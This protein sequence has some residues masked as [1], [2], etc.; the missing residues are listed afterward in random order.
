MALSRFFKAFFHST[1]EEFRHLSAPLFSAAGNPIALYRMLHQTGWDLDT[2]FGV[3]P[4]R[5]SEDF[6]LA[7]QT[8]E[9]ISLAITNEDDE[10][11]VQEAHTRFKAFIERIE[12]LYPTLMGLEDVADTLDSIVPEHAAEFG[13][14]LFNHL[15]LRYLHHR[16]PLAF[17]LGKLFGLIVIHPASAIYP[18]NNPSKAPVRYPIERPTINWQGLLNPQTNPFAALIYQINFS[19]VNSLKSFLNEVQKLFH[20]FRRELYQSIGNRGLDGMVVRLDATGLR[21]ERGNWLPFPEP[22]DPPMT[23]RLSEPGYPQ[24]VIDQEAW[25]LL[26][27]PEIKQ[28]DGSVVIFQQDWV[29]ITLLPSLDTTGGQ[30][31]PGLYLY[32]NDNQVLTFEIV[33]GVGLEFPLEMLSDESGNSIGA[34]AVGRLVVVEGED[35]KLSIDK[36]EITGNFR[37]G[38][39]E[40]LSIQE[41]QLTIQGIVL[42][43]TDPEAFPFSVD[44]S[45]KLMLP[46][47]SG[48]IS[49]M[50]R[51]D[52]DQVHLQTSAEI[53]L[54]NGV[55]LY[56]IEESRPVLEMKAA[57][58]GVFAFGVAA[59]F[60]IPRQNIGI[61]EIEI[62]GDLELGRNPDD[63]WDIK[64]FSAV[65]T[66]QNLSWELPGGIK[67]QKAGVNIFFENMEFSASLHGQL[68]LGN[69]QTVQMEA[70]LLFPDINDPENIQIDTLLEVGDL[71]FFNQLYLFKAQLSLKVSTRPLTGSIEIIDGSGGFMAV[72]DLDQHPGLSDFHLAVDL[73]HTVFEFNTN[74]FELQLKAGKFLLPK[75]FN[76]GG[77]ERASARIGSQPISLVHEND[78]LAFHASIVLEN[79]GVNLSENG[80]PGFAGLLETAFLSLNSSEPIPKIKG[81]K[82]QITIPLP[83]QAPL[84]IAFNEVDWDLSG[85]PTGSVYLA[86]DI[87]FSLGGGFALKLLGGIQNGIQTGLTIHRMT[88]SLPQFILN[89]AVDLIIPM[90]MLTS[91]NGD[92]IYIGSSGSISWNTGEFPVPTLDALRI[93]G[94]FRLGGTKGIRIQDGELTASGIAHMLHP[95]QAQPFQLLLSGKIYLGDN[96]PGAGIQD[97][98]FI[99]TGTDFPEFDFKGF[100][101]RPGEELLGAVDQLPLK[102][103]DLEV[104]FIEP[105]PMPQR[106]NP[107]NIRVTLSAELELP[108]PSGGN[109]L[110]M[111]DDISVH[112]NEHGMPIRKD[113]SSGIDIDGIG[114]GIDSFE[115]GGIVLNGVVYLGGL[116]NPDD[117]FFAGKVG[118]MFNG[119]GVSALLALDTKGPR[120]LCLDISGGSAGISLAYGFMLTGAEGGVI[121]PNL[122]GRVSNADPCDIRTYIRI[123]NEGRPE[124]TEQ[125]PVFRQEIP[126]DEKVIGQPSPEPENPEFDCPQ[127]LCPPPAVS[128]ISQ[129]H[130]DR[131]KY[132]DRVILKLTCI[133]E[134]MLNQMGITPAFFSQ[135]GLTTP[136]AIAEAVAGNLFHL[137]VQ[138]FPDP[139]TLPLP[140]DT[141]SQVAGLSE[142]LKADAR[143]LLIQEL[144][145]GI[146]QALGSNTSVYNAVRESAYA[147]I[148]SPE[149]TL[150]LTGS[151]SYAG[152]SAF[153]SVT[154]GFSITTVM[155]PQPVPLISTV[156]ILGSINLLGIPMGTAR[157]FMNLTDPGG[158]PL[159]LPTICGDLYA[160]IGPVE[161]G[162]MR[163]KF[164]AEGMAEGLANA[165]LIFAEH[166]SG[167]LIRE[168]LNIFAEEILNHPDFDSNRP[169]SAFALLNFNQLVAFAGGLINLPP[170]RI[171][172]NIQSCLV[173]LTTNA[174][175]SF[176]PKF[177]LCGQVQPKIFGFS[178]GNELVSAKINISKTTFEAQFGFS[179][180]YIL[181]YF[182]GNIF[183]S[184]DKAS[185]GMAFQLPDPVDLVNKMLNTD[186]GS[187]EQMTSYL[188]DG[189]EH[190]LKNAVY[191]VEYELI[192]LGLKMADAEGRLIM[193]DLINH[194]ARPV[195][196]WKRPED[197]TDKI[198]LSRLQLLLR[199]LEVNVLANPLWKGTASDLNLLTS[200]ATLGLNMMDYFPHGGFLGAAKL[201]FPLVLLDGIPPGLMAEAFTQDS[202]FMGRFDAAKT[203][204]ENYILKTE[205]IGQL[206][207]YVPFPNPPS[208]TVDG[209][210]PTPVQIVKKMQEEALDWSDI[211]AGPLLS[212]E[213][214]FFEGRIRNARVLGVPV[215]EAKVLAYGP[216]PVTRKP[217]RLEV[218]A[219][220]PPNSWLKQFVEQ[221][222]LQF[223][224]TGPPARPVDE[225]F[226]ELLALMQS[227]QHHSGR[228][229][230]VSAIVESF[231]NAITENLPQLI[232]E[233]R[234]DR[235]RIPAALASFFKVQADTSLL[236]KAYSPFYNPNAT[237]SG[238]D[239]QLQRNG[240]IS[241]SF[242]GRFGVTGIFEIDIPNVQLAL[243]PFGDSSKM[244]KVL[245]E[246]TADRI[247]VPFGLPGFEKG[248]IHFNSAPQR[249]EHLVEIQ[250]QFSHIPMG[251][252]TIVPLAGNNIIT[253]LV[254]SHANHRGNFNLTLSGVKIQEAGF[255][256]SD[257]ALNGGTFN[258]PFTIS[259]NAVWNATATGKRVSIFVGRTEALQ[260]LSGNALSGSVA[261]K[262][263]SHVAIALEIPFNVQLTA[264][265]NHVLLHRSLILPNRG[266][267]TLSL[268]SNGEFSLDAETTPFDFGLIRVS[269]VNNRNLAVQLSQTGFRLLS[270]AQLHINGLTQTPYNLNQMTIRTDT[271]FAVE[272]TGGKIG[273]DQFFEISGGKLSV[274]RSG[275]VSSILVESSAFY[276]FPDTIFSNKMAIGNFSIDSDGYFSIDSN[277]Q[278]LKLPG[279]LDAKG[280]L[281]F[282]GNRTG[283]SGKLENASVKLIPLNLSLNGNMVISRKTIQAGFDS[284]VYHVSGLIEISPASW[285]MDWQRQDSFTLKA[286]NPSLKILNIS[287][288]PESQIVFHAH[289]DSSFSLGFSTSSNLNI[290]P[291][292]LEIGPA[293]AT[294]TK[295][296]TP[297]YDLIMKAQIKALKNP[298]SGQWILSHS[299]DVR[300][301]NGNFKE[302]ITALRNKTFVDVGMASIY[303]NTSSRTYFGRN[304]NAYYFEFSN[305]KFRVLGLE[306]D[307]SGTCNFSGSLNLQWSTTGQLHLG[308]FR[309]PGRK[310]EVSMNLKSQ[311]FNLKIPS[312]LLQAPDV[313]GFPSRG[314]NI[315]EITIGAD[316]D[317]V[318]NLNAFTFNGIS[319]STTGSNNTIK[320]YG[321]ERIIRIRNKKSLWGA[322]ADLSL[323]IRSNGSVIG[324]VSG[325]F[326]LSDITVGAVNFPTIQTGSATLTYSSSRNDYQ[327]Q[328]SFILNHVSGKK[329]TTTT[330]TKNV[331]DVVAGIWKTVTETVVNWVNQTFKIRVTL[332]YGS[333][334]AQAEVQIL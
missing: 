214:A 103:R 219:K 292:L 290:I 177:L 270:G 68:D 83:E 110:G 137:I 247:D 322:N 318:T 51:F 160:G 156:G 327:F 146:S 149:T 230:E 161:F 148:P 12:A 25:N 168:L 304:G 311:G 178:I 7:E 73:L 134:P 45:G 269:G 19:E 140:P 48:S 117:L 93:G 242:N 305:L 180:S 182:F 174:W 98:G 278:S 216:D 162:Q 136:D 4:V 280:R 32:E 312:G 195:S 8:A 281:L 58:D 260:M 202:D 92:Q 188:Q 22:E 52:R 222:H 126:E 152:V 105:E 115:A 187:L 205:D 316:G 57:G 179:P 251:L 122:E 207:F 208:F 163:M 221:A 10:T 38:G 284:K 288:I 118:G 84:Q 225:Y 192:P 41:A 244:P 323:D 277:H 329:K 257:L 256:R 328:T 267:V 76:H 124:R 200:N 201:S 24:M 197:R 36:M 235:M 121:F 46:V 293:L 194:P 165:G 171:T 164:E 113:G 299:A 95:S 125:P 297:V 50:L 190:V 17:S 265:P 191:T 44:V 143:N 130:P 170:E 268:N 226:R 54:G 123:N 112:F 88:N 154:G 262:G 37:F 61:A 264:F 147:G 218:N 273:M 204:I 189:F 153:L 86:E 33:G 166:L 91:E 220:I 224:L 172:P 325:N 102:V 314:I 271:S 157:L 101:V 300:L 131:K 159:L 319:M 223:T 97:A 282:T 155:I 167:P 213:Q 233:T 301:S 63:N 59:L 35:P 14:D 286:V 15:I 27:L 248:R 210:E 276:L 324:S 283:F 30:N 138:G 291:G 34:G 332:K 104:T 212:A 114:M 173:Q 298:V 203:I 294:L 5:L 82:G 261:G 241:F 75:F 65:S 94:S 145:K 119:T 217:G 142:K 13:K 28:P 9:A 1:M 67:V 263:F 89:G 236:I 74:G 90:D 120:G 87:R 227:Y 85:Y 109:L 42:P 169:S 258:Q 209:H 186:T 151:F 296:K 139:A 228:Y 275:N 331:F 135:L 289:N 129:P 317:F 306:N 310:A 96:G 279:L 72:G 330:T 250:G 326:T 20:K 69:G 141:K 79:I 234:A 206:G 29:K 176:D 99:F 127:G 47:A 243:I 77:N 49:A 18:G 240:G 232:L 308:P 253:S 295:S 71:N 245:G 80:A 315:P 183:P 237:G 211:Q 320:L 196:K 2:I 6:H 106:L 309:L 108:L 11:V 16:A 56:P 39:L 321:K 334:G 185:V 229:S 184:A 133:D 31:A 40:G 158:I 116:D 307:V 198:Y 193:P 132:P 100:Y 23:I 62:T 81:A 272:A 259:S 287:L 254:V 55:W 111:V 239:A 274:S 249:G 144:S 303:S 255:I 181:S 215:F 246:F 21:L 60:K 302:E 66:G 26:W 252:M 107:T 70:G 78:T 175:N 150:K 333:A 53:H 128:I 43:M 3:D 313:T 285:H 238:L 266:R 64:Q 231:Q 199:A